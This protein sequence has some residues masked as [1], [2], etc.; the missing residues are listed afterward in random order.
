M[1]QVDAKY[2]VSSDSKK[3]TIKG[4]SFLESVIGASI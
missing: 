1:Q 4:V 3:C 2:D